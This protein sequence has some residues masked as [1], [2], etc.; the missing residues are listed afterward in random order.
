[1]RRADKKQEL[2]DRIQE[3]ESIIS[4][5]GIKKWSDGVLSCRLHLSPLPSGER[6]RGIAF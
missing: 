1:M 2:E 5:C 3:S 4:D 6:V